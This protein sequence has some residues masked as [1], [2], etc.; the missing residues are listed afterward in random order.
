MNWLC[1]R[2]CL[3]TPPRFWLDWLPWI[4]SRGWRYYLEY[5]RNGEKGA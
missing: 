1:Y 4:G 2:I 3:C 5:P